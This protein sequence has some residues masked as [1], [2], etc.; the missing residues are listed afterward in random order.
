MNEEENFKELF[1]NSVKEVNLTKKV[2][3]KI[4]EIT[5]KGEIFVD[6]GYKAD[7][8][9]PRKE[10]SDDENENPK[11]E[12][13]I[14]DE[15]SA[16]ILKMNDGLGNV[17]LSYKKIKNEND[18]KDIEKKIENNEIF[19]E[20]ISEVVEK[21]FVINLKGIRVFIPISLSGMSRNENIEDYRGKKVRFRITEYDLKNRKVIGSIKAVIQ[22]EKEK[23]ENEFWANVEVGKEYK[24]TVA[25]ISEYG[26]FVD[27]GGA[28]GLLHVSEITWKRNANAKELLK[29]NQEI[30]VTIK[31]VDKENKRLKLAY[32]GKGENPWNSI[33]ERY[34][35]GDII[36]GQVM[37]LTPFGAFIVV[38]DGVE[39]LVH[40]SQISNKRINTPSDVLEIGQIVKAKII[41]IDK[42]NKKMEL[43]IKETLENEE[44]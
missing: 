33:D 30:N 21:G 12:F 9:I 25:S 31:E 3:G 10:Y 35:L 7:G 18:R 28:Q 26:A 11:D 27:I 42:E 2:T 17:L 1:E 8:I 24:G 15:I 32:A 5:S 43:S 36:E 38:E 22:E 16:I 40:I 13:K 19:E 23:Q 41:L 34:N 6:L 29:Q 20:K 14:G 44:E 39:G 4:I 37:N